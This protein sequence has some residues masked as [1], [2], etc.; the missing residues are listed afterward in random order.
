MALVRA[1]YNLISH[2]GSDLCYHSPAMKEHVRPNFI[3]VTGLSGAG[4][5]QAMKCLEDQGYYCVDNLPPALIP[6]LAKICHTSNITSFALALDVRSRE[7]FEDLAPALEQADKM[8]YSPYIVFLEAADNVLINRYAESR[9]Q[10]PLAPNDRVINGII[11]EREYLQTFREEADLVIDTSKFSAHQ[12]RGLIFKHFSASEVTSSRI[13]VMSFGFKHGIPLDTDLVFDCRFLPNP[14]Y[15]PELRPLSGLDKPVC[16]YLYTFATYQQ[17]C[18][19]IGD[20]LLFLLP[21]YL[22]E[23][24]EQVNIAFGCTGGR[25]RSVALAETISKQ[26][27]KH[28]YETSIEHRDVER[29]STRQ[30]SF[31]GGNSGLY[32][33][34]SP[35]PAVECNHAAPTTYVHKTACVTTNSKTESTTQPPAQSVNANDGTSTASLA[36]GSVKEPP[37]LAQ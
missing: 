37:R 10:H 36:Q 4:K 9:R 28:G 27:A 1:I 21:K 8:G 31:S 12:L 6:E 13:H 5:S 32:N 17:F 22:Q 34:V 35:V 7:F 16:D 19:K 18:Q 14:Y 20:L 3:I 25:H 33:S 26:L 24:K 2:K 29:N 30:A 15:V 11:K 23:G